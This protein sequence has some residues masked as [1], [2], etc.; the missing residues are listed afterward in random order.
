MK[1]FIKLV[2]QLTYTW[3][4]FLENRSITLLPQQPSAWDNDLVEA[5]PLLFS[6]SRISLFPSCREAQWCQDPEPKLPGKRWGRPLLLQYL[7]LPGA[8]VFQIKRH[9][10]K[11][12]KPL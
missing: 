7:A 8:H 12:V 6:H 1:L 11:V 4:R 2:D 9:G 5:F 10:S 3:A